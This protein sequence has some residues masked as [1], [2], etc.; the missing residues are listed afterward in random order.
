MGVADKLAGRAVMEA[1]D[2]IRAGDGGKICD[3]GV[4]NRKAFR[5]HPQA[6]LARHLHEPVADEPGDLARELGAAG[7]V[8]GVEERHA[9]RVAG[10]AAGSEALQ[11]LTLQAED[12]DVGSGT[13]VADEDPPGHRVDEDGDGNV[14]YSFRDPDFEA[15]DFNSNL[16]LRWEYRPGSLLYVVWSQA[17]S[18]FVADGNLALRDDLA[19]LF[20]TEP[21]DVVLVKLSKWFS[22]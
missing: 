17:R 7:P 8:S 2:Q 18:S 9:L 13:L 20:D 12:H 19:A 16:V 4:Q 14:D 15:R 11:E 21:H 22:L 1:G 5:T 6:V 3:D 10:E